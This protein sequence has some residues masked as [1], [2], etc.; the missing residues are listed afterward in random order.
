M[1]RQQRRSPRA[2]GLTNEQALKI[3]SELKFL[4]QFL[5]VWDINKERKTNSSDFLKY[6]EDSINAYDDLQ[7]S[8]TDS[9]RAKF[10]LLTSL[11]TSL[12]DQYKGVSDAVIDI[13]RSNIEIGDAN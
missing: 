1:N 6:F 5:V 3:N 4:E 8:G 10:I 12:V 11:K 13:G 7:S 9:Q 2:D